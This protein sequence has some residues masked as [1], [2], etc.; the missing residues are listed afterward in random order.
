MKIARLVLTLACAAILL[1]PAFAQNQP[2]KPPARVRA[3][4]DGFDLSPQSGKSANQVGGASRD[5]GAPKIYAPN[6]GKA[7][8]TTPTFYWGAPDGA[9]KVTFKL[10]SLNGETLYTASVTADHLTYP[11]DAPPLTPGSSYRWT[12]VP[13][14]DMLG[15]APKAATILIVAAPER[16][17]I[18]KELAAANT[19]SEKSTIYVNHRV[20]YDA[21]DSYT[22]TLN[23]APT[24][25][26]AR[27]GRATLYDSI[28][29]TKELAE[30]DW[31]MV[32]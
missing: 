31:H 28:P 20:W 3:K 25:Q 30:A 19:P 29:A 16:D 9:S 5:L 2:A 8:S 1:A 21:I 26:T 4:L 23:T 32:H 13:E 6:S 24:D 15:G 14:N 10:T 7:F 18:A 27:T 12:I 17:A 22:Q 11:A